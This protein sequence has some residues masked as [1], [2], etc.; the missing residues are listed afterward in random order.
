LHGRKRS[1]DTHQSTTAP[2][3]RLYKKSYGKES[4]LAY[5][6]HALVQNR[7]GLIAAAMATQ[8]DGYSERE[9]ALLMHDQPGHPGQVMRGATENEQPVHLVQSAQLHLADRA[10]LLQPSEALL[11]QPATAQADGIAGVPGGSPVESRA[12]FLVVL[13]YMHGD[14]QLTRGIHEIP[15]VEGL[16][17]ARRD[18]PLTALLSRRNYYSIP[19]PTHHPS[20]GA[21]CIEALLS[22]HRV[23]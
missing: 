12:A 5:L 19:P 4:H 7:N 18:P 11:D 16:G 20:A 9:A 14:I 23:R 2:D 3:A 6:G 13:R 17:R 1:N 15:A 8:A 21:E 10:G 22:E